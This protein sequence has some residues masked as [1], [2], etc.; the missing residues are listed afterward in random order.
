MHNDGWINLY[1]DI[2]RTLKINFY[3]YRGI[4]YIYIFKHIDLSSRIRQHILSSYYDLKFIF[5]ALIGLA[6]R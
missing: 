3:F 1:E 5:L 2:F 4:V 6:P